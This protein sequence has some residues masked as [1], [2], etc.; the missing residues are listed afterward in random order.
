MQC[1]PV[2]KSLLTHTAVRSIIESHKT[3]YRKNSVCMVSNL[4]SAKTADKFSTF[5]A[6]NC[7]YVMSS[8]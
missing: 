7:Y 2:T 5:A 3:L 8:V 4:N 1:K 6:A